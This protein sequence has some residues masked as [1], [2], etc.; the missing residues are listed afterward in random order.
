MDDSL[1]LAADGT[2]TA[3]FADRTHRL[4]R[5]KAGEYL[6][7]LEALTDLT[8]PL[9]AEAEDILAERK[10]GGDTIDLEADRSLRKREQTIPRRL[11]EARRDWVADVFA[12]LAASPVD[13]DDIPVWLMQ[14]KAITEIVKQWREVP[15]RRGGE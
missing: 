1:D 5:P 13:P 10:D 9:R 4:R 15:I 3:T 14:D 12:R 7:F 6:D 8:E 11:E 2:I